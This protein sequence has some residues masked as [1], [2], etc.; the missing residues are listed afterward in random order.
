MQFFR[1]RRKNEGKNRDKSLGFSDGGRG[2]EGTFKLDLLVEIV[3][4][5]GD[6]RRD[7][8]RFPSA[9]AAAAAD[10]RC[11]A[12]HLPSLSSRG[13]RRAR[14]LSLSHLSS[15]P[16]WALIFFLGEEEIMRAPS[17]LFFGGEG[18]GG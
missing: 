8:V 6:V 3:D 12:A 16:R 4:V 13:A 14:E 10:G 1:R 7:A 5:D 2:G 17:G 15:S 11:L 18:G 9:A